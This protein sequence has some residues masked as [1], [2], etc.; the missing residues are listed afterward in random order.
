LL[1]VTPVILVVQ[2]L[3]VCSSVLTSTVQHRSKIIKIHGYRA[4]AFTG[5][6]VVE[7]HGHGGRV[8][9]QAILR[10]AL[11]HGARGALPGEFT[12]RAF[13]NGRL[14]LAQAE[15]VLD[16]VQAKTE[17]ALA[18]AMRQLK[19]GLSERIQEIRTAAISLLATL[20]ASID[21]PEED[22]GLPDA[23]EIEKGLYRIEGAI[24]DLLRTAREGRLLRQGAK[25]VLTGRPNVGKSSLLNA[26]LQ[27]ERAIISPIPGTT[28]DTVEEEL[29]IQGFPVRLIDTAG[30]RAEGGDPLEREGLRRTR[31]AL[32][33]ADLTL[34]ILDGHAGITPEDLAVWNETE[35][36]R[37]LLVNK[38]DLPQALAPEAYRERLGFEPLFTSA[39]TGEGIEAVKREIGRAVGGEVQEEAIL[40]VGARHREAL[41]RA[42]GH[43]EAARH[44]LGRRDSFEL[45]ALD[46]RGAVDALGEVLGERVTEE[47]LDQIFQNFCIG[48]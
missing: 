42:Q 15:A 20:E 31:L 44:A 7:I 36:A 40:L 17:A 6:D 28:R 23:G 25:V 5:E 45:V 18:F 16:I 9:L 3:K 26:L 8:P 43:L 12:R 22:L 38:I 48:K 24:Q 33:K 19:G 29:E 47:V 11:R 13:V 34:V 2:R 14:D 10:L 39:K 21:F 37:R 1:P 30:F 46:V 41:E 32:G 4:S 27:E 35:G